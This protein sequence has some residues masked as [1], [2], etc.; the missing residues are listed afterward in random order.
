M[1]TKNNSKFFFK[2]YILITSIILIMMLII[3]A[4]FFKYF[5]R[6]T[7]DSNKILEIIELSILD[8]SLS[9]DEIKSLEHELSYNY[10]KTLCYPYGSFLV[11]KFLHS[12]GL[13]DD[14]IKILDI[15]LKKSNN[16]IVKNIAIFRKA[17]LLIEQK[18]YDD[19]LLLLKKPRRHFENLFKDRKADIYIIQG[20]KEEG[21]LLLKEI[22]KNID[23]N[24][25][26]FMIIRL[27]IDSLN[28][29]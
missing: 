13:I 25:P 6:K 19:A 2:N 16:D 23:M 22:F 1:I 24:D 28:S 4:I 27:K 11:S 18:K 15:V 3:I 12:K 26:L 29:I 14:A 5:E 17:G 9:V 8:N 20:K 21:L 7:N 10:N